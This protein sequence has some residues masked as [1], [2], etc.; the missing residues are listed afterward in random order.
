VTPPQ[1]GSTTQP[2]VPETVVPAVPPIS[3]PT[4]SAAAGGATDAAD[5]QAQPLVDEA[6]G[7]IKDKKWDEAQAVLTKLLGMKDK[8]SPDL[9]KEIASLQTALDAGKGLK[10]PSGLPA[11]P[12]TDNK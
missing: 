8:L 5:A 3:T 1:A 7:D 11:V 10:L 2:S 9:Q 6:K 4:P 12:G